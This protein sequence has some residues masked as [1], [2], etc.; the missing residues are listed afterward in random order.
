MSFGFV[1]CLSFLDRIN[2]DSLDIQYKNY[3]VRGTYILTFYFNYDF[4]PGN[5][6]GGTLKVTF[7][8]TYATDLGNAAQTCSTGLTLQACTTT[9][10]VVT[11]KYFDTFKATTRY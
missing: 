1:D 11:V 2:F 10:R 7:P 4:I 8:S 6:Y 9:N 5:I 3:N